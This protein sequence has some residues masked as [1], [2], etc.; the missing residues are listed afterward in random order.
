MEYDTNGNEISYQGK[1]YELEDTFRMET[2]T[3]YN[4]TVKKQSTSQSWNKDDM[5]TYQD[6]T[7][8]DEQGRIHKK[9]AEYYEN[10]VLAGS[11]IAQY[12]YQAD[13]AY[14]K[15]AMRFDADGKQKSHTVDHYDSEGNLIN[16]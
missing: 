14:S 15:E 1:N 4:G 16:E 12:T 2:K 13:G 5:L 3:E 11:Y 7:L 9:A 6:V 10:E 8:Y